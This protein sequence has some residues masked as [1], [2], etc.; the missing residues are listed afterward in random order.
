MSFEIQKD[1]IFYTRE[2]IRVNNTTCWQLTSIC[3]MGF[4]GKSG[5]AEKRTAFQLTPPITASQVYKLKTN[6]QHAKFWIPIHDFPDEQANH[7]IKWKQVNLANVYSKIFLSLFLI[8]LHNC[9]TYHC[10]II[11]IS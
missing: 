1:F 9:G 7:E 4:P 2:I 8:P 11:H 3:E 6:S 10:A 5:Q